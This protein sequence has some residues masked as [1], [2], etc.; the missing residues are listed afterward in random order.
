MKRFILILLAS[1]FLFAFAAQVQAQHETTFDQENYTICLVDSIGPTNQ[2]QFWRVFYIN[3]GMHSDFRYDLATPYTVS[4]TVKR[5]A[6]VTGT[7]TGSGGC[8]VKNT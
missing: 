7:A 3:T 4:G 5:C 6:S 8:L 1:F 2:V